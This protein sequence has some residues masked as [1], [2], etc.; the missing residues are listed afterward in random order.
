MRIINFAKGRRASWRN[1]GWALAALPVLAVLVGAPAFA[2]QKSYHWSPRPENLAGLDGVVTRCVVSTDKTYVQ[3]LCWQLLGA[4][5][6]K[7]QAKGLKYASVGITWERNP[8]QIYR[9]AVA[10]AGIAAPLML[11]FFIRGAPG[12]SVSIS[13]HVLGSVEYRAAV[14]MG[15][16]ANPRSGRLVVWETALT[17]NGPSKALVNTQ[18]QVLTPVWTGCW[19]PSPNKSWCGELRKCHAGSAAPR[20]AAAIITLCAALIN[21]SVEVTDARRRAGAGGHVAQFVAGAVERAFKIVMVGAA[22]AHFALPGA[23]PR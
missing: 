12:R 22:F 4:A 6:Q 8:D 21:V 18:A 9:K 23:Q 10:D 16:S 14:E 11:E 15:A 17:G 20:C 7:V 1:M 13:V 19:G 2:Q 3:D 5:Q